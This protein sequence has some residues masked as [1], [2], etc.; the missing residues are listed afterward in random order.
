MNGKEIFSNDTNETMQE[1][2]DPITPKQGSA[3]VLS[4][5]VIRQKKTVKT[6]ITIFRMVITRKVA[7]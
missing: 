2:Q 1:L 5:S 7:G 3:L 4:M 6:V